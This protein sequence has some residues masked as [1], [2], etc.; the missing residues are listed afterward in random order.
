MRRFWCKSS[1]EKQFGSSARRGAVQDAA[2]PCFEGLENRVLH[3]VFSGI[4]NGRL[5]VRDTNV[6]DTVTLD[7][8]GTNTI[9]N[10]ASYPDSLITD[11][12]HVTVGS[13]V[14]NFDIVNVRA[15]GIT[16]F[17]DGQFDIGSA[18]VGAGG[19]AQGVLAP[20][21]FSNFHGTDEGHLTVDDSADT[22]GRSASLNVVDGQVQI[23]GLTP[24]P[25][26]YD[27]TGVDTLTLKGGSGGNTFTV[28]NTPTSGE[29]GLTIVQLFT[30]VGQDTVFARRVTEHTTVAIHGQN[31]RDTV[32]VGKN[33]S[34]QQIEGLI[35]VFNSASRSD[36]IIDDS[37]DTVA[38]NVELDNIF[39]PGIR[40]QSNMYV[41]GLSSTGSVYINVFD[42]SLLDIKAGSGGNTFVYDEVRDTAG[43]FR[44]VLNT[45]SGSDT[46]RVITNRAN[47]TLNGQN[48]ND[49]VNVGSDI[50]PAGS[51]GGNLGD[52][53]VT[54]TFAFTQLTLN[55]A[56]GAAADEV[57]FLQPQSN[58]ARIRG[59]SP[60][61]I[62]YNP[63]DVNKVNI[64]GT[65]FNDRFFV[66]EVAAAGTVQINGLGGNDQFFVTSA[67]HTLDT[68]KAPLQLNGNSGFDS[69]T[70]DD[71]GSQL[72]HIY[73]VT[74]TS[75]TRSFN[76]APVV[77]N[78]ASP[79]SMVLLKGPSFS[80]PP[81]ARDLKLTD[82]VRAGE[83]ATLTGVLWDADA[84]DVLSLTVDW[85]DGSD[86]DVVQSNRDP[87]S[88]THRYTAAGTYTVRAIWTDSSGQ[89]NFRD[90]MLVVKKAKKH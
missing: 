8:V 90:L 66:A 43:G 72:A 35:Q 45:G 69:I 23:T 65:A 4:V 18:T 29:D 24:A 39:Q 62:F 7:H 51:M 11:G 59:L 46:T 33:G 76:S 82:K 58:L 87:F 13:G 12:V 64:N 9:V 88:V 22:V 81:L 83:A 36:V 28:S 40:D 50:F 15:T 56:Q 17:I 70:I 78:F 34:V 52:V 5:E 31:G 49:I 84:G 73:T 14:G 2:R 71:Q 48:G 47:L 19:N 3:A 89:S 1:L 27:N 63:A 61:N 20:V 16:T 44:A 80:S 74:A 68:I 26:F 37:A 67:F 25:V 57:V 53:S 30:G 32:N 79:E 6:V 86:P 10:G 60:G 55:D 41:N 75:V 21:I 77:I 54:N 42:V 85:G 38:R